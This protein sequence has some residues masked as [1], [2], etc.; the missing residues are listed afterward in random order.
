[1]ATQILFNIALAMI[2]ELLYPKWSVSAFVV[3]Y[4]L[5]A[6]ILFLFYYK[7]RHNFYLNKFWKAL[8]LFLIFI[9]ELCLSSLNVLMYVC[10][11]LSH[12]K[13]G[14]VEM[15][16]DED[17]KSDLELITLANMITLTPGT[18]TLE[19]S[20]DNSKLYIHALNCE[21]PDQV[22]ADIRNAFERR[23]KEVSQIGS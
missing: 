4:L 16:L 3:G 1:M 14:I 10:L 22:V 12:L 18:L 23:I 13:P 15:D 2:W 17:L 5:G 11:P 20:P 19:I 9:K 8:I 21:D 6:V 7:D